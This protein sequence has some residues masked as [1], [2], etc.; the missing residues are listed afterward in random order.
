MKALG[1]ATNGDL[2]NVERM[3]W[4]DYG[5]GELNDLNRPGFVGGYNS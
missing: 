3:Y 2:E 5:D 4:V 1:E